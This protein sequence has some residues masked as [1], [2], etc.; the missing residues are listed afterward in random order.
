MQIHN[1]PAEDSSFICYTHWLMLFQRVSRE[2][3]GET[4]TN[5]HY[6][7]KKK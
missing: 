3:G 2:Q 4:Q 5:Y 7:N 6:Q 1:N